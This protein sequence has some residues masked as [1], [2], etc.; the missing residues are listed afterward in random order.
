MLRL[1]DGECELVYAV[2]EVHDTLVERVASRARSLR[3]V[4]SALVWW[5]L[6]PLV[7]LAIPSIGTQAWL[8]VP[9]IG[10][11]VTG[12]VLS[13]RLGRLGRLGLLGHGA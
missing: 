4:C 5:C 2:A 8:F 10:A 3:Q 7:L 6:L 12:S 13:G 9:M 11:M 1:S